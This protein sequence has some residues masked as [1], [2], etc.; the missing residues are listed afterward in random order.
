MAVCRRGR[1]GNPPRP[2]HGLYRGGIDRVS[3]GRY[4]PRGEA[5]SLFVVHPYSITPARRQ[6][7]S[8]G[9]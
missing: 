3:D 2:S 6:R 8:L 5:P 7:V 1:G 9:L 4:E